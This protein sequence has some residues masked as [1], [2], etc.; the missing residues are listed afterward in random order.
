MGK[1]VPVAQVKALKVKGEQKTDV[2]WEKRKEFYSSPEWKEKREE[3]MLANP[4][5]ICACCKAPL[6]HKKPQFG[7]EKLNID[8]IKPIQFYWHMRLSIENLQY[9]CGVCN[10]YK[11]DRSINFGIPGHEALTRISEQ[12][13]IAK[14]NLVWEEAHAENNGVKKPKFRRIPKQI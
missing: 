8:H 5:K 10:E 13:R 3:F 4:V 11:L 14:I 6:A 9:L 7:E 2:G 12:E 1:Y